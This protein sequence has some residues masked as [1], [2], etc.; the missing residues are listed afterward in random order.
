MVQMQEMEEAS[1]KRPYNHKQ[2]VVV[3]EPLK[4]VPSAEAPS[5]NGS[6]TVKPQH[7]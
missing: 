7:I 4:R 5:Q 2:S 6:E 3:T 1:S